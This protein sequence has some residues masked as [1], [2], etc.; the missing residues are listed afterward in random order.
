MRGG[1]GHYKVQPKW[2]GLKHLL[3]P[4]HPPHNRI[5]PFA[6]PNRMIAMS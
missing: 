2:S 1:E 3:Q 4:R 6:A 5:S